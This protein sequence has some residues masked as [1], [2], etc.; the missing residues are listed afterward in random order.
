MFQY[1]FAD[2][3]IPETRREIGYKV[4]SE[5]GLTSTICSN[6]YISL[7]TD[8]RAFLPNELP[9]DDVLR[10]IQYYSQLVE[11]DPDTQSRLDSELYPITRERAA[12][13]I[14]DIY[15]NPKDRERVFSLFNDLF[16][17]LET[18]LSEK[19]ANFHDIEKDLLRALGVSNY[20][21]MIQLE[22]LP[23]KDLEFL[24]NLAKRVAKEFAFY[25]R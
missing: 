10:F 24:V 20:Y 6:L 5:Q 12:I 3:A 17:R 4:H 19:F 1:L 8:L 2:A 18:F 23:G 15:E 13:V 16:N 22:D 25:A 14:G 7:E 9:E 11:N 21:E